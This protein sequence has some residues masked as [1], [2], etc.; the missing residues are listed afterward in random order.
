M[1][2]ERA[3]N[4]LG[5]TGSRTS[6]SNNKGALG[7]VGGIRPHVLDPPFPVAPQEIEAQAVM[8]SVYFIRESA[9]QRRP[10]G[11]IHEAFE[12]R[13]LH[14]LAGVQ[15]VLSDATKSPLPFRRFCIYIVSN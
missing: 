11:R 3:E 6:A 5:A 13:F 2:R 4:R 1:E 8:L 15:A 10:L 12:N 9:L 14:A 7:I